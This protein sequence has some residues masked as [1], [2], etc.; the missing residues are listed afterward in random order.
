MNYKK[1]FWIVLIVVSLA[2]AMLGVSIYGVNEYNKGVVDSQNYTY[3]TLISS[4]E[5]C[6][7]IT[8]TYVYN[9]Q[10]INLNF[11]WEGCITQGN[12]TQ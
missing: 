1:G 3:N 11:Y 12:K 8:T 2:I 10:S 6:N 9:N 4:A 5:T 7:P